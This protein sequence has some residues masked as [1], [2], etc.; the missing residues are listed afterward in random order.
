M[1]ESSNHII[2]LK[3]SIITAVHNNRDTVADAIESI[4]AQNFFDVELILIDGGSTDGTVEVLSRYRDRVAVLIS[5]RDGGIYDALNKGIGLATGDVVGFLHS[6]DVLA[7]PATLGRVA[8]AFADDAID[9]V[10]GDLV[11]VRKDD[12]ARVVRQWTAGQFDERLLA[13]GWMPPHPTFYARR[14]MYETHGRFDLR[15]SIA[16]DY[17]CMLR[18]L[19][20][21]V[22]VAYIPHI[23]VRMRVGGASNRS[24]RNI[25]RKSIEDYTALQRNHVGG[26]AALFW[27]NAS[28]VPQ[29]F[30]RNTPDDQGK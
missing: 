15:L 8:H 21:G 24:L 30:R 17:D 10:Y 18:F 9:A 22:R 11:Y 12:T 25:V 7:D 27:K 26:I 29:F 5:E 28:K 4:L 1:L 23:Q 19:K 6:D 16:A 20:A 3:I 14:Q 13:R 2:S